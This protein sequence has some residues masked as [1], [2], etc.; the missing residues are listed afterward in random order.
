MFGNLKKNMKIYFSNAFLSHLKAIF[1]NT[2]K[3]IE[4]LYISFKFE[5]IPTR[6]TMHSRL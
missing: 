6:K 4:K 1:S 2:F 3:N 5:I